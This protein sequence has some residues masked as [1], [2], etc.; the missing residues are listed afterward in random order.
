MIIYIYV[1]MYEP[2]MLNH[3]FVLYDS[4]PFPLSNLSLMFRALEPQVTYGSKLKS[5]H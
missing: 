1:C 2:Q 4:C 3:H 5:C